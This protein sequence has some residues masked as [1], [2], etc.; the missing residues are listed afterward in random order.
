MSAADGLFE[1][2]VF[3]DGEEGF[4]EYGVPSMVTSRKGTLMAF[5]ESAWRE[6]RKTPQERYT[7]HIVLKRSFDNGRT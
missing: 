1:T 5:C 3:V 4:D 7:S 6:N 2:D